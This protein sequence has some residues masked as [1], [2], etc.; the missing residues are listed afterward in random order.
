MNVYD[1]IVNRRSIRRFKQK[2]ISSEILKKLVNAGRLAPS[3]ANFQPCEYIII[4]DKKLVNKVFGTL[5]WAGYIAPEGNPKQGEQP[6]A[7]IVVLINREK[8]TIGGEHDAAAAI[9]NIILT[10]ME[11]NIGTCWI[12]SIDRT[13]LRRILNIPDK[14]EIDSVLALGYPNESPKAVHMKDSIKYWKDA[15]G[16]LNVPKRNLEDVCFF[17]EYKRVE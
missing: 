5:K 11:E 13:S 9:E 12:G 6:V 3:G 1:A 4:H 14:C 2:P 10:A 15:E 17:D 7:Y 16:V 8:R